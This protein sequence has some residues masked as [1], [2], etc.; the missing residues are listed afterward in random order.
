MAKMNAYLGLD[1]KTREAMTFYK[2]CLG[3][4]LNLV[5]AAETPVCDEM[6]AEAKESIMHA[7]LSNGRWTLMATDMASP[8]GRKQGN[9]FSM[10]LDCESEEEINGLF[11]KLSEGGTVKQPLGP[12]FWGGTFGFLTDKFGIGWMFNYVPASS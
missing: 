1:G 6:P 2:E 9:D 10:M 12:A 4:E 7:C 5:T 3:G 8:G 11:G